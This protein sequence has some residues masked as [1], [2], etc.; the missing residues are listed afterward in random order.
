MGLSRTDK[1]RV[2]DA[3][4]SPRDVVVSLLPQ[5]RDLAGR[6]RGKTCVGHAG[7]RHPKTAR[8]AASTSTM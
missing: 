5:P 8:S 2:G 3:E 6:M 1:V 4:V 7:A